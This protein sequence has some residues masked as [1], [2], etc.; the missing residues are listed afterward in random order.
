M[1]HSSAR[2]EDLV[3]MLN[4]LPY[5]E[6]HPDRTLMEAAADLGRTPAEIKT[7]L[8]RLWCC[9][10]PGMLPDDLVDLE[11]SYLGVNVTNNQGLDQPLRLTQTEAG[12]LLLALDSLENVAGLTD[13][14]AVLSAAEKLRSI[15][16]D[17]TVAVV[18]SIAGEIPTEPVLEAIRQ[19]MEQQHRLSFRY[20]SAS[21]DK[22]TVRE[23]SPA[24][25]FAHEGVTYLTAWDAEAG[26]HRT[27][28]ADRMTEVS[29]V[30]RPAEPHTD[31]LR[32][33]AKNPF[34]FGADEVQLRIRA[35]A[36]WLA[37]YFPMTL[38]KQLD[39]AWFAATMPLLSEDW[40]VRFALSNADRVS[41]VAPMS[42]VSAIAT[43][44]RSALAAYDETSDK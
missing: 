30:N 28:R 29:V 27:F 4:L 41:I 8:D 37:D 5:F 2:L 43:Q 19:A 38:G 13:R 36:V 12:A 7:D 32:F 44:S 22:V 33:D 11:H 9:G 1:A 17:Q 21:T 18:D 6:A 24:R 3:R 23:V 10:L 14:S 42:L 35:S 34:D 15:M 40:V 20:H 39:D 16:Q 26:A 25:V 31:L